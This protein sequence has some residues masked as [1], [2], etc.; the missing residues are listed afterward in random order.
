MKIQIIN[1][2]TSKIGQLFHSWR[3]K[4]MRRTTIVLKI[5]IFLLALKE[6]FVDKNK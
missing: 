4:R 1:Y 2:L 6:K 3:V 5:M